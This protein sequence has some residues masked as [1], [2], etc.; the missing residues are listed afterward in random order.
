MDENAEIE[1]IMS[2]MYSEKQE[3]YHSHNT[4][5]KSENES[6]LRSLNES[7]LKKIQINLGNNLL[8]K[9]RRENS[10]RIGLILTDEDKHLL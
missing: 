1:W 3:S 7:K 8:D 2:S 5:Y 10:L 4:R 6:M 9:R